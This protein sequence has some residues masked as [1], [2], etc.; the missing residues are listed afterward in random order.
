MS[1]SAS[2]YLFLSVGAVVFLCLVAL[3]LALFGFRWSYI[4]VQNPGSL[5][6]EE[7]RPAIQKT[8]AT[9]TKDSSLERVSSVVAVTSTIPAAETASSTVSLR[10]VGDIMLDR[11]VRLRS[12]KAGTRAYPFEKLPVGWFDEADYAIANLEGPITPVRRPPEKTIDFQFDSVVLPV[13]QATGIDAFSQANNHALDQGTDGYVD[14]VNALRRAGFLMFGHQVDD[15]DISF[16]TTTIKGLRVAF[17]GWNIT[18]NPMNR[19]VAARAIEHARAQSD[20]LIAFMHWGDEYRDHP[21]AAQVD[22]AHWL[23]DH[24]IDVVMGGHPHWVEGIATYQKKPIFWSLGN[25]IFD[26]DFSV[27]TKQ[28]LAVTL[29]ID[30]KTKTVSADLAPVQ[31]DLSQPSL[32][33]SPSELSS[34]LDALAAISQPDLQEQIRRGQVVFTHESE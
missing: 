33:T 9:T 28:G 16:A 5:R 29:H 26:Q 25:F 7:Q 12:I 32:V 17:L 11:S 23:I 34:R 22:T 14:S 30:P 8:P 3:F 2:F 27:Q 20:V 1:R 21:S 24:G 6:I 19:E 13:L 15:G 10:F 4:P 18:D 31:I